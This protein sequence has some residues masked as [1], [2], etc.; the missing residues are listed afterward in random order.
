MKFYVLV[1]LLVFNP[2]TCNYFKIYDEQEGVIKATTPEEYDRPMNMTFLIKFP[3]A[4]ITTIRIFHLILPDCN[5]TEKCCPNNYLS[6]K[7]NKKLHKFCNNYQ[8]SKWLSLRSSQI[9]IELQIEKGNAIFW[10]EYKSR[11]AS[12]CPYYEFQCMDKSFCYNSSKI[13]DRQFTCKDHS[14]EIGC[15]YCDKHLVPC[16][17][18]SMI[19]FDPILQRCDKVQDCPGREDEQGCRNCNSTLECISNVECITS[20][21][22]CDNRSE[23]CKSPSYFLCNNSMCIEE[24]L[25]GNGIDDCG[26]LSDEMNL[27]QHVKTSTMVTTI[28]LLSILFTSLVVRWCTHRMDI[29]RLIENPP[30]FPLPPFQGPDDSRPQELYNLGYSDSDFR[31]GGE[32]F[33]AFTRFRRRI[34]TDNKNTDGSVVCTRTHIGCANLNSTEGD[35]EIIKAL[36]SLSLPHKMCIGLDSYI[37]E[38][39]DQS[40]I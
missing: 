37:L 3:I 36:V 7:E 1:K 16:D 9:K 18:W 4:T 22:Q 26:D 23:Y 39:I 2:V 27:S 17:T 35:I 25:V 13:C 21:H 31:V 33:E 20:Q 30:E 38:L 19:C 12:E 5:D 28:I 29:Q 10:I 34:D 11:N 14:D 24:T 32:V 8:G 40:E 6:I 15:S